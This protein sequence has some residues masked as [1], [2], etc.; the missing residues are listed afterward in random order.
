[1]NIAV[2]DDHLLFAQ[3]LRNSL[4]R[5]FKG[6]VIKS[7]S[8]PAVFLATDFDEWLPD[9]IICDLIMPGIDGM[10]VVR[11]IRSLLDGHVKII[12]MSGVTDIVTVRSA[13]VKGVNGYVAKDADLE[14]LLMA[15]NVVTEGGQ[16]ISSKLKEHILGYMLNGEPDVFSL[17]PKEKEVLQLFCAGKIPKEIALDMNLSIHTIN[18]YNKNIMKKFKVNRTTD[19]ILLAIQRGLYTTGS[20]VGNN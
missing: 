1:M 6:S 9:V 20:A 10:E 19:M 2:V 3:L 13:L 17:S 4:S 16:Y 7:F 18:Q 14:E 11:K 12:I 5:S 8:D 15:I